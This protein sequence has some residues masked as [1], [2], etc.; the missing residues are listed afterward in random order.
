MNDSFRKLS[1][2]MYGEDVKL[3]QTSLKHLGFDISDDEIS[4]GIFGPKQKS[5]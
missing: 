2:G 1:P 4:E 3:L 5:L